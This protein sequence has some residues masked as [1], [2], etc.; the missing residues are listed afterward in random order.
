MATRTGRTEEEQQRLN[1]QLGELLQEVRVAMP[2]VQVLFAF[3]LAVPFNQRFGEVTD[4]QRDT[5]LVALV[6]SALASACFIAPTAYHRVMFRQHEKP[7]L[8]GLA[9]RLTIAGLVF[10]MVA[11]TASV[12]LVTDFLFDVGPTVVV[13][14]G[15]FATFAWLWFGLA[16]A[17]R[18][19]AAKAS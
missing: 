2:G 4:L 17:R 8:I 15:V 14:A 9:S 11:M 3:L 5:Y 12:L 13:T 10:L 1:R 18:L 16:M 19:R 7:Y 6:C